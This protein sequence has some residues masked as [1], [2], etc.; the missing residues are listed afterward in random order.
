MTGTTAS[1]RVFKEF[2]ESTSLHGYSYL[3]SAN[4]IILKIIWAFVIFIATGLGVKF[5]TDQTKTYLDGA[6]TTS[7]ET[8]SAPLK[9]RRNC[10][11]SIAIYVI[12]LL[13]TSDAAD[14]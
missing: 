6:I 5:L 2:C 8:Y 12:C 7:I 11:L 14:E 1:R 10:Q 13:Y 3:Y 4:S 9:V